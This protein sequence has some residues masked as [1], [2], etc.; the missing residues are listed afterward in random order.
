M[1]QKLL[2]LYT[3]QQALRDFFLERHFLEVS[4]PPMVKNPGMEAHLHPFQVFH[5]HKNT[6]SHW[7]L[8]TSPEFHMKE[9]LSKGFEKIFNLSYCFRDEPDSETHRPQFLMLEWYR[10]REN[11]EH[12]MDD[13]RG[14]IP[15]CQQYLK[16]K[17]IEVYE[18][19]FTYKE[20]TV[21][22]LFQKYLGFSILEYLRPKDLK[23][24]II[25][26]HP[27]IHLPKNELPWED[28]FFLLFL[29]NI[30]P[31]FKE[32]PFLLVKEFPAP[33]AA[34]S[35]LKKDD[36]RVCERFEVYLNGIELCNCFNELTDLKIQKDRFEDE[37]KKKK[38]LYNYELPSA[39]VLFEALERGLPESSGIALGVERLLLALCPIKNP[40]FS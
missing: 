8:H 12:I 32:E 40:F 20:V 37:G 10:A 25:K 14:L 17:K 2:A 13:C 22:E 30:E 19:E 7:Y 5:T 35:T 24:K 39:N 9:L 6:K 3:L 38:E 4:T 18:K 27:D 1:D 33:L 26:D 23:E 15:Y 34:L 36:P 28:Y 29:N 21:D 31:Y 11:Y 16:D